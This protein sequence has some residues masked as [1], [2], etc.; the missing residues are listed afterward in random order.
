MARTHTPAALPAVRILTVAQVSSAVGLGRER[1]RQL[2][3]AGQFP[4]RFTIAPNGRAIGW[5]AAEIE[6]WIAERAAQ[7]E[8]KEA[9]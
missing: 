1:I 7:R 2:E 8:H 9:A 3:V 5:L 6:R 4:R